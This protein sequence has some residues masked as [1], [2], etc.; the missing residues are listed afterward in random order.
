MVVYI[1]IFTERL[2]ANH[3]VLVPFL[4]IVDQALHITHEG[5][6]VVQSK[7][8]LMQARDGPGSS[9]SD[10]HETFMIETESPLS[11]LE[12]SAKELI[13]GL[14][15]K[16]VTQYGEQKSSWSFF[17]SST[18]RATMLIWFIIMGCTTTLES[19]YSKIS[20]FLLCT[21]LIVL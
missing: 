16:S 17:F 12:T 2:S 18:S 21:E 6:L 20:P 5:K 1:A 4:E 13:A 14:E 11:P 9:V 19:F 15:A 8:E 10:N 7:A 3:A